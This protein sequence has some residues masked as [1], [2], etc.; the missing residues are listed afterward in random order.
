[1]EDAAEAVARREENVIYHG[2]AA[3]GLPGLMT[4]EGR[5]TLPL[6]AWSVVEHALDDVL[7]GVGQLDSQGFNGP[8]VLALS[9]PRYNALFHHYQ[10]S[11]MLQLDHLRRLC[12]GGVFKAPIT[13][14]VLLDPRAGE[15]K[16]G[17]DLRVGFAA[18]DGTHLKL[19]VSESLALLLDEPSAICT[20]EEE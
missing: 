8:Y 7:A 18:N 11:D 3:L 19:F 5:G 4:V 17:Q 15:I 1:M 20:L 10:G 14:A 12:Q 13:G 16:I 2:I 9:P 6:R